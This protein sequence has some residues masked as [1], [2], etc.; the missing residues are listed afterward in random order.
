MGRILLSLGL[1]ISMA[2][3]SPASIVMDDGLLLQG[4]EEQLTLQAGDKVY[5]KVQNYI[6][7]YPVLRNLEFSSQYPHIAYVDR[8]GWIHAISP[9]RTV[10]SV[11]NENG[12]NGTIEILV[13]GGNEV[14][15]GS[16]L[17]VIV[18]ILGF[19]VVILS[20]K[21]RCF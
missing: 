17:L 5:L 14:G 12:D 19:G 11:W 15:V 8:Y 13:E 10:I 21:I 18:W 4:G 16:V 2:L 20:K 9:G 1:V 3:S 7:K 6:W